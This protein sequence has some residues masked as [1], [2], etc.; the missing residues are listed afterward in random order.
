MSA[1]VEGKLN[2][3]CSLDVLKKAIINIAPEW[4]QHLIIDPSGNVPMYRYN[5]ERDHNG[6]GGN[7]TVHLLIPGSGHPNAQTPPNRGSH[8]D[9]G[10]KREEDGTWS[11]TFA[12]YGLKQAQDL[13]NKIKSEVALMK[14]KAIAKLRGY[15]I[16]SQEE[17]E[18]EKYVDI[19]IDSSA[20]NQF[21]Q[22]N[23]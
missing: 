23:T 14:A 4:E 17:N 20:Y 10:F 6:Q 15:E 3:K 18:E 5:G 7:K 9:W 19:R 8:N 16:I 2:L 22:K 13:E 12:D 1:W 21:K 11:V